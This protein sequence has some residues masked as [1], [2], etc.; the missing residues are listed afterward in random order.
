[1]QLLDQEKKE[2]YIVCA[3][4][5]NVKAQIEKKKKTN[6]SFLFLAQDDFKWPFQ[7]T[8]DVINALYYFFLFFFSFFLSSALESSLVGGRVERA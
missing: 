7:G 1:M 4:G 6:F 8:Y 3:Y 5:E 2:L